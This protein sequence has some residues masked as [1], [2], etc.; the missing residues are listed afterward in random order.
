[1]SSIFLLLQ[2]VY[3]NVHDLPM[4]LIYSEPKIFTGGIDIRLWNKLSKSEKN[5]ALSKDWYV[6][7]SF[8][9]PKT[10]KLVRQPNIKGGANLYK[11]KRNR[12]FILNI[13]QQSALIVLRE[14]FNPYN[15]N[16][17]LKAYLE[18]KINGKTKD[19]SE[20]VKKVAQE[21]KQLKEDVITIA[22]AFVLVL[23]TKNKVLNSNSFTKFRSRINIFSKWLLASGFKEANAI[24]TISKKTVIHH[25]NTVL[26]VVFIIYVP[27]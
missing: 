7:Y 12:Y 17:T 16:T 20:E 15:D 11:D 2:N 19:N 8:R 4:K 21:Q 1:M 27:A 5:K 23:T 6:Y 25:L 24:T 3:E 14:G 10:G 18:N 13:I 9:N 26:A 22:E